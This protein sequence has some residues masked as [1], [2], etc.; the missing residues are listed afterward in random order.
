[1][2]RKYTGILIFVGVFVAVIGLQE[3]GI[4]PNLQMP[5]ANSWFFIIFSLIVPAGVMILSWWLGKTEVAIG[6]TIIFLAYGL[7]TIFQLGVL[8]GNWAG[9]YGFPTLLTIGCGFL[10]YV[11]ARIKIFDYGLWLYL[12][13]LPVILLALI[14][15]SIFSVSNFAIVILI[16]GLITIP[17]AILLLRKKGGMLAIS[18]MM[19]A[20]AFPMKFAPTYLS[21]LSMYI[22]VGGFILLG[23]YL[24]TIYWANRLEKHP[25]DKALD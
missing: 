9:M 17:T 4:I 16:P 1:M 10:V 8:S 25:T 21:W 11:S 13:F 19:I 23:M 18:V 2:K 5:T 7:L 15:P 14:A 24:S 20:L 6:A 3:L 22:E 12:G